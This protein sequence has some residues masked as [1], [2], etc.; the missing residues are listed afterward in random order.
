MLSLL[1]PALARA[2]QAQEASASAPRIVGKPPTAGD[3]GPPASADP[4]HARLPKP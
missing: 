2:L 1:P 3:S 4:R